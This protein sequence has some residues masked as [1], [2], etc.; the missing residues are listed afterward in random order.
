MCQQAMFRHVLHPGQVP[1]RP[2]RLPTGGQMIVHSVSL[3]GDCS[4]KRSQPARTR[5]RPD[6]HALRRVP[7]LCR[8][9][10]YLD[11]CG[12]IDLRFGIAQPDGRIADALRMRPRPPSIALSSPTWR[13]IVLI[14]ASICPLKTCLAR[15][16][17]YPF[18]SQACGSAL[19]APDHS[20]RIPKGLEDR[21]AVDRCERPASGGPLGA[22]LGP[23]RGQ[24]RRAGCTTRL[25]S[26]ALNWTPL[27]RIDLVPGPM[28]AL[29]LRHGR[30]GGGLDHDIVADA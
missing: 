10:P 14:T 18:D 12:A 7:M 20:E 1:R 13:S 9:L 30:E 4:D 28:P 25:I 6:R 26:L 5:P 22:A 16:R 19:K 2:I 11:R 17:M 15:L 23:R 27:V 29:P 8:S 21:L 24:G 3:T